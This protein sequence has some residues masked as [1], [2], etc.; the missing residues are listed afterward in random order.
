LPERLR[1]RYLAIKLETEETFEKRKIINA[2][3]DSIYQLFGE[4][5]AS[6]TGLSMIEHKEEKLLMLRCHHKAVDMIR[7]AIAFIT[8][9]EDK[10]IAMHVI[11]V[12]G[13]IK[14]L[15]RKITLTKG[16]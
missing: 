13:T 10:P 15:R 3:W 14:A 6:K 11:A 4:Y 1:R 5:G 16:T 2:I 9:I 12:S 8:K 7:A